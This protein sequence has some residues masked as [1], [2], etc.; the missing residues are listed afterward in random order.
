[1]PWIEE[2]SKAKR[3][4]FYFDAES[5]KAVLTTKLSGP[6]A[7]DDPAESVK[8]MPMRNAADAGY[9]AGASD[10]EHGSWLMK[11]E[12]KLEGSVS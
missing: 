9:D 7:A 5:M 12:R 3:A 10:P 1:M 6:H 4:F 2:E 11:E 8:P